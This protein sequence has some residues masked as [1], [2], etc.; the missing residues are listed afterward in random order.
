MR[1]A[2]KVAIGT[3]LLVVLFV[4]GLLY[5]LALIGELVRSTRQL[6][7]AERLLTACHVLRTYVDTRMVS[8]A[9]RNAMRKTSSCTG[10]ARKSFIPTARHRSRSSGNTL[11]VKAIR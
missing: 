2:S 8:Q 11:A 7:A 9:R 1:V 5:H 4:A 10:L 6:E 3:G